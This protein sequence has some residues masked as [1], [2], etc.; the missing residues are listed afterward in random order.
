M[1]SEGRTLLRHEKSMEAM[2]EEAHPAIH[3][4][5]II[6]AGPCGLAV[7][8]RLCEHTPSALFTDVEHNRYHWIKKHGARTAIKSRKSGA[9]RPSSGSACRNYSTL[10]LDG[11]GEEWMSQWNRL[12]ETFEIEHL[13]SPTFFHPDPLDRDGLLAFTY[14][15]GR[16]A[17]LVE[18]CGCVGKEVS[19]HK[20]KKRI[21]CRHQRF[22]LLF[23]HQSAT[24]ELKV[25]VPSRT[26]A[27]VTIDERDRKDY[28]TPSRS[29]F[30]DYC[31]CVIDR[32]R[33]RNGLVKQEV[34]KDID[35]GPVLGSTSE[36]LFSVRTDKGV[37]FAKTVVLAVGAGNA[38][39]V[40]K[41]F[42]HGIAAGA[43]HAMRIRDFPDPSVKAKMEIGRTT[44]VVVIGGG[45][46]SAQ[47]AD[48]AIR[49]GVTKVWHLMRG[50][51]KGRRAF[52]VT[53]IV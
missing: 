35:Y 4:V 8:A 9:I 13:R 37:Q 24:E 23:A 40:P 29:L 20:K 15:R 32:Y 44:N 12:F 11:S 52:H 49:H 47:V 41:P 30:R 3:D 18:I 10:V 1:K 51:L 5:L 26:K 25:D 22:V 21:N 50:P 28:F 34:V 2:S 39:S 43:C 48:M 16:G 45:L 46:T 27:P 53:K 42:R 38:P 17:E 19:K 14:E 6:G 7:A 36:D 33:L 31:D